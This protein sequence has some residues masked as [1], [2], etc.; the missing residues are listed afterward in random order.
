MEWSEISDTIKGLPGLIR[1]KMESPTRRA[2]PESEID[3]QQLQQSQQKQS[4][5]RRVKG[6]LIKK[7]SATFQLD[8][9]TYTIGQLNTLVF[10]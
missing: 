8:G 4:P 2:P 6:Q 7:E 5:V 10:C 9:A 1:R 3:H